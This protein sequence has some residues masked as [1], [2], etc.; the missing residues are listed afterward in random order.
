M[1]SGIL[2]LIVQKRFIIIPRI[3]PLDHVIFKKLNISKNFK[4]LE[5]PEDLSLF[6]RNFSTYAYNK[7]SFFIKQ[8]KKNL[9]IF[10]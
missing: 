9:E 8:T 2:E 7:N 3:G 5:K 10:Q 6:L 4:V 1:T